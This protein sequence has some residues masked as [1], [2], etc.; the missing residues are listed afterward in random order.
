MF[1]FTEPSGMLVAPRPG[2]R[3]DHAL[4]LDDVTDARRRAVTFDQAHGR[5]VLPGVRPRPLDGELLPIGLGA[6]IP[7][8]LP[9]LEPPMPRIT[10]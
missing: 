6:V 3:V 1:D 4:H 2:E 9:S 7:L 10:A 5:E 8:P